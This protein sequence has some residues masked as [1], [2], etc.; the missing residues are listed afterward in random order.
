M[1]MS[2]PRL[3]GGVSS[4]ETGVPGAQLH[5]PLLDSAPDGDADGDL[6]PGP[7]DEPPD[8]SQVRFADLLRAQQSSPLPTPRAGESNLPLGELDPEVL[9]RLAAE[10][11]KRR[12]NRGAHFY[13]RRGQ[14]QYGLDILEREAADANSVY[15]VRRYEVLTA[16]DITSAVTEYAD[17]QP[18]EAG[19]EKPARRFAVHRY[20]LFTSAEFET[21][22]GEAR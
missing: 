17:P 2:G 22:T 11:I 18:P 7:D 9:E 14:K 8:L 3:G 15:Q 13:G 10:M 6:G 21:E 12:P 5:S 1:Q 16:D 20:V 4:D 19:G